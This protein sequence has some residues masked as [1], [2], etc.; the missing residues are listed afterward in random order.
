MRRIVDIEETAVQF[1]VP[2]IAALSVIHQDRNE[3]EKRTELVSGVKDKGDII[4]H[5][6]LDEAYRLGASI[7]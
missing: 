1:F 7:E 2:D 6:A 5:P 3:R 4:G